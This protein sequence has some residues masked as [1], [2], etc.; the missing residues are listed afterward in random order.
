M[1]AFVILGGLVLVAG[2]GAFR[3]AAQS[4]G[5][6]SDLSY[7]RPS[8]FG[9]SRYIGGRFTQDAASQ[10]G[11][12]RRDVG[13]FAGFQVG[14]HFGGQAFD[15]EATSASPISAPRVG[16]LTTPNRGRQ[17]GFQMQM[18]SAMAAYSGIDLLAGALRQHQRRFLPPMSLDTPLYGSYRPEL[19]PIDGH[20]YTPAPEPASRFHELTGLVPSVEP[21][22]GPKL[23]SMADALEARA[24]Q[25]NADAQE[26][27]VAA[28]RA[29]TMMSVTDPRCGDCHE[30]VARAASSLDG[31]QEVDRGAALPALLAAH[32]AL[33]Q[34]R[35]VSATR[36]IL[37]A[38]RRD[39]TLFV[40]ELT[41]KRPL[42]SYFGDFDAASGRSAVLQAQMLRYLQ[43]GEVSPQSASAQVLEAYC[44]FRLGEFARVNG[45]LDRAQ[46]AAD[47]SSVGILHVFTSALRAAM[48]GDAAP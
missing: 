26:A 12:A 21:R 14:R 20:L 18:N 29:A 6:Q 25:R 48:R 33:E 46:K 45:A 5:T 30:M 32:I 22:R 10:I 31:V 36:A 47:Q 43:A 23:V 34:G 8:D 11:I 42:A 39:P 1:R 19:P 37:D 24:R 16:I 4:T 41:N 9:P 44:A 7:N 40:A 15:T 38:A 13:Q 3:A 35:V 27:A 17:P 28:F 2:L